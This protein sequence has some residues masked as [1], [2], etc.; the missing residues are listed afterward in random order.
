MTQEGFAEKLRPLKL[1]RGRQAQKSSP[2][3]VDEIR[4]LRAI[5]GGLNS[6]PFPN[7]L[8]VMPLLPTRML[9][10]QSCSSQF[11]RMNWP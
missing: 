11:L 8:L 4:C 5:N 3:T 9:S 2:L 7:P 6:N 10:Y 1:S